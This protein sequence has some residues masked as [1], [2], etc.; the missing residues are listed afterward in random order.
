MTQSLMCMLQL[1]G[2]PPRILECHVLKTVWWA[3]KGAL[4]ATGSCVQLL[5][6]ETCVDSLSHFLGSENLGVLQ[7]GP[8]GRVHMFWPRTDI[9]DVVV[10]HPHKPRSQ[11][12]VSETLAIRPELNTF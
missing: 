7:P 2:Y 12:M 1:G 4:S 9:G 8:D 6:A 5:S 3:G 10:L 11:H